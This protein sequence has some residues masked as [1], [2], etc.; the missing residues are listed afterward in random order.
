MPSYFGSSDKRSPRLIDYVL[1]V[2]HKH[3]HKNG[4]A[5][6]PPELLRVYPPVPHPDFT[7]PSD[8]VFFCQPEGCY[9]TTSRSIFSERLQ[10][11]DKNNQNIKTDFFSFTLTD[12]ESNTTRY[13]VCLN[14]LRPIGRRKGSY[15]AKVSCRRIS[16][17]MGALGRENQSKKT[18]DS[19]SYLSDSSNSSNSSYYKG[20]NSPDRPERPFTHTLTSICLVSQYQFC[21]KFENCLQF[22][23]ML[24][25]KL[26]ESCK[27]R[28]CGRQVL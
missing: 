17:F 24:V 18:T 10:Y 9:N 25:Q 6:S 12:K 3:P 23:Y 2:G 7:L 20:Q 28:Y 21:K 19:Y 5:I 14:F 4:I 27:P 13:G 11:R 8:V 22:L 1:F 15:T 16:S 26:H